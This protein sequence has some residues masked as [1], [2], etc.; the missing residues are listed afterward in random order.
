MIFD[1]NNHIV[2]ISDA[3]IDALIRPAFDF[4]EGTPYYQLNNLPEFNG[5]GVYAL[6]LKSTEGT[7]YGG[8]LPALH[9]IYVGKAVP[10]GSRKGLKKADGPALRSRLTKHLRSIE[11]AQN[12]KSEDFLCRFMI[13]QGHATDMI[14]AMESY[15]IRQYEPLWN[16]YI[17]GFGINAPGAGRYN[18]SPSE[19]DTLHQG[20][21][22]AAQLTG[23]PRDINLIMQKIQVYNAPKREK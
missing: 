19:W 21:Y 12:L 17:D 10:L 18:Q 22:Y 4:F 14:S 11:Q 5:A 23:Q 1:V 2:D 13:M 20:R 8:I 16:A 9:P 6:F 15:L 7:C 3:K